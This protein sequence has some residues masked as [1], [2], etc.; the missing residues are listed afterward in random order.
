MERRR[1]GKRAVPGGVLLGWIVPVC[2]VL[3]GWAGLPLRPRFAWVTRPGGGWA[4]TGSVAPV[5]RRGVKA[6]GRPALKRLRRR[7]K[8]ELRR[9]RCDGALRRRIFAWRER[10]R[11]ERDR[12]RE[13]EREKR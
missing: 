11:K 8:G 2:L 3:P 5:H 12:E 7:A 4:G 1:G 6:L 10:T 9:R 13:K